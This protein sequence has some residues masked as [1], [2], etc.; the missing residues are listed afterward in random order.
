MPFA[1]PTF[2]GRKSRGVKASSIP[3]AATAIVMGRTN[4]P[5]AAISL[6]P[7]T[8]N[9]C[10]RPRLVKQF[11][12]DYTFFMPLILIIAAAIHLG[13]AQPDTTGLKPYVFVA[14]GDTTKNLHALVDPKELAQ[15]RNPFLNVILDEPWLP[16]D[17]HKTLI[18]RDDYEDPY[19]EVS[20][21]RNR[22]IRAG[23]Q[24]NGGI[25][26]DSAEGL[27]WVHKEEYDLAKR[28]DEIAKAAYADEAQPS[29][30][31]TESA[32]EEDVD[33]LGFWAEWRMHVAIIGGAVVLTA[34]VIWAT[35]ARGS[36]A[37]LRP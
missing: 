27:I 2:R 10:H 20:S 24:E 9:S 30:A 29:M 12:T 37:V 31:P 4:G 21:A 16:W 17:Q 28:A 23:W 26:V 19:P 35:M 11:A 14:R 34:L 3:T 13:Q 1:C 25:E 33:P 15:T 22:R 36:W 7:V 32:Q 8:G 18:R 6:L 5:R